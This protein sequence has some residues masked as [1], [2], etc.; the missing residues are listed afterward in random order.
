MLISLGLVKEDLLTTETTQP[1]RETTALN[2]R[3]QKGQRERERERERNDI[4]LNSE[5]IKTTRRKR[6]AVT[7]VGTRYQYLPEV[8]ERHF[9]F[10][11][12]IH[13]QAKDLGLLRRIAE[14]DCNCN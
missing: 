11:N 6:H 4:V 12:L 2:N 13:S 5:A 7:F 14:L 9:G 3:H 8:S 10:T 1:S